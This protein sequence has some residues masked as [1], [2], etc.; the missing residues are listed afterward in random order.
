MRLHR[1]CQLIFLLLFSVASLGSPPEYMLVKDKSTLEFV[2]RTFF[3]S[4]TGSFTDWKVTATQEGAKL[5]DV[6]ISVIINIASLQTGIEARDKHLKSEDF[7]SA[8]KYPLASFES[9]KVV[10]KR[11]DLYQVEGELTLRGV[12]RPLQFD[13]ALENAEKKAG[14]FRMKGKLKLNRED[15]GM[16]YQPSFPLPKINNSVDVRFDLLAVAKV[17]PVEKK[18]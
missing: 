4:V 6:K 14:N 3:F 17:V 9:T 15:F 7:F 10:Q 8:E 13:V 18:K 11:D 16:G 2:A 5:S 1:S 12:K